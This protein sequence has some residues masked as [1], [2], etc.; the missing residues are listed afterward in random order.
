MDERLIKC[1]GRSPSEQQD[2]LLEMYTSPCSLQGVIVPQEEEIG[3]DI[4][5]I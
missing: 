1:V 5:G 2:A 4:R 3:K